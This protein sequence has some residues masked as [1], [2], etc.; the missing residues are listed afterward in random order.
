MKIFPKLFNLIERSCQNAIKVSSTRV[1]AYLILVLIMLLTLTSVTAGIYIAFKTMTIPNELIVILGMLL[2]HQL[3]LL[4]INKHHETKQKKTEIENKK[5]GSP[6]ITKD[7][8][9]K[10]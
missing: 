5:I 9:L 4:G 1:I 3:T 6:E 7:E 10:S 2:A 8:M